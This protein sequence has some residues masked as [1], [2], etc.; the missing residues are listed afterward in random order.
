[1][2]FRRFP[3][4]LLLLM[5]AA[6]QA[7]PLT[8][9]LDGANAK[10]QILFESKAPVEYIEGEAEQVG[11]M[12]NVDF[13]RPGL[14]LRASISVPVASMRTGMD[15]RDEHLRS[16]EWLNAERYPAIKFDLEPVDP[17]KLSAR[18]KN[19]WAGNVAG[20]FTLKGVTKRIS[21]PVKI[22]REGDEKIVVE[23]RF[24]VRLSDHNVH[25]PVTMRV[26]GMKVSETVQVSFKLVGIKDKGWDNVKPRRKTW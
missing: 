25:G 15:K 9:N 1:M 12:I 17:K 4:F 20:T 14:A 21:V 6:A 11:G 26:I 23:G 16:P 10:K 2:T 19:A 24:P 8:F 22:S 18:G 5:P 3:L 7:R 13:E